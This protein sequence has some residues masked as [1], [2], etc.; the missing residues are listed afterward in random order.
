MNWSQISH[1]QYGLTRFPACFHSTCGW[2]ELHSRVQYLPGKSMDYVHLVSKAFLLCLCMLFMQGLSA[3]SSTRCIR[4]WHSRREWLRCSLTRCTCS[5]RGRLAKARPCGGHCDRPSSPRLALWYVP[6]LSRT[7]YNKGT[8]MIVQ[9]I[10]MTCQF[11]Q[12]VQVLLLYFAVW[13]KSDDLFRLVNMLGYVPSVS[14]CV[15]VPTLSRLIAFQCS[16]CWHFR[17]RGGGWAWAARSASQ[18]PWP[19]WSVC[20]GWWGGMCVQA[21]VPPSTC[22]CVCVCVCVLLLNRVCSCCVI[23]Q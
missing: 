17:W 6:W 13:C 3:Y 12:L 9:S 19:C 22:V 1:Y 23:R 15:L 5:C 14:M 2:V 8:R 21:S 7:L 11:L 10:L 20:W 18:A 16:F 4:P